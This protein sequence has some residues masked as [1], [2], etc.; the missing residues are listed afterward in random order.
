MS[1]L[2]LKSYF[3]VGI[4]LLKVN[5]R[6]TRTKSKICPKL[7]KKTLGR[8]G[9]RHSGVFIVNLEHIFNLVL[10][11]VLLTLCM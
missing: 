10:V 6:N 7:A 11:F 5:N 8:D 3:S 2:F 1:T 9:W 4:Y